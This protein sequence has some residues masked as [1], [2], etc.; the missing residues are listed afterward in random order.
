LLGVV[1][2]RFQKKPLRFELAL[3]ICLGL[4]WALLGWG[5]LIAYKNDLSRKAAQSQRISGLPAR[6][7][8]AEDH[9]ALGAA[10]HGLG[11]SPESLLE[12]RAS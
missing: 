4:G 2:Q 9:D 12:T 11:P 7:A 1:F 6:L 10:R 5:R 3:E 8:G